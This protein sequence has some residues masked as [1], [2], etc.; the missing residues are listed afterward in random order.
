MGQ[1]EEESQ[2]IMPKNKALYMGTTGIP[3]EKMA[4]EIQTELARYGASHVSCEYAAGEITGLRWIMQVDGRNTVF[5]MPARVDAIYKILFKKSRHPNSVLLKQQARRVA[6][7]QLLR[8]TQ[9]QL[10]MIEVGMVE[11]GE[12]FFAYAQ[13]VE[14]NS[15]YDTFKSGKLLGAGPQIKALESGR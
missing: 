13:D 8:W 2:K 12:V 11:A 3:A 6:W 7:R 1:D 4:A 9:A 10:A 15:I 5:A 14:G